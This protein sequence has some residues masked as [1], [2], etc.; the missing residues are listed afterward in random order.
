MRL[1]MRIFG[2]LVAAKKRTGT[3]TAAVEI[4]RVG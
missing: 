3:V 2:S 1:L 4:Q